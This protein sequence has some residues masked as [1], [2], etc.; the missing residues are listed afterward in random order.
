MQQQQQSP[1]R[2]QKTGPVNCILG[3]AGVQ[4]RQ[5]DELHSRKHERRGFGTGLGEW[6][7]VEMV[8]I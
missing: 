5:T 3:R 8:N 1:D 6:K 2:W 7:I 4:S